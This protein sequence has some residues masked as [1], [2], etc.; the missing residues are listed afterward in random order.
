M[1]S[2][3]IEPKQPAATNDPF[4]PLH[5][6]NDFNSTADT[7]SAWPTQDEIISPLSNPCHLPPPSPAGSDFDPSRGAKPCS[8]FYTHP[9]TRT[10]LEQLRNEAQACGQGYK[11]HDVESAYQMPPKPSMDQN[12]DKGLWLTSRRKSKWLGHLTKKQRFAVKALIAVVI[13]G[14]MVGI[15][16]GVTK[17][18]G[19]GVWKSENRQGEIGRP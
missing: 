2:I 12:S 5:P 9:T 18:V 3:T 8:P 6:H 11:L 14:T 10:S 13:V 15:G 7:L 19:G 16:L 17:A 4:S 1:A